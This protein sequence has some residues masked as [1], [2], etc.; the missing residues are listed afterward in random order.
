MG[1]V[2]RPDGPAKVVVQQPQA[3]YVPG[4]DMDSAQ[5]KTNNL[6]KILSIPSRKPDTIYE[7]YITNLV[8]LPPIPTHTRAEMKAS[9]HCVV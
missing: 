2:G 3:P 4:D 9:L 1:I 5:S 7:N 8:N 6:K